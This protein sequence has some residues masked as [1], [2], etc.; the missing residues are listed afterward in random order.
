MFNKETGLTRQTLKSAVSCNPSHAYVVGAQASGSK[1]DQQVPDVQPSTPRNKDPWR[2][3]MVQ[4][5][6]DLYA[7]PTQ[8]CLIM[9]CQHL[10][11]HGFVCPSSV[12][13]SC[14]EG[15]KQDILCSN[16]SWPCVSWAKHRKLELQVSNPKDKSQIPLQLA[17]E[18]G[19]GSKGNL[20]NNAPC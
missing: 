13:H 8:K 2:Q 18:G 4:D 15:D 5:D 17:W 10:S 20:H 12:T 7:T 3:F 6:A 11:I 19:G 14:L 9:K 16:T 1:Y